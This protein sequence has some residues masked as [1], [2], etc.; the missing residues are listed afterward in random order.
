MKEDNAVDEADEEML[1]EKRQL[2]KSIA[3]DSSVSI[4]AI[5][6]SPRDDP[7]K[8]KNPEGSEILSPLKQ[9]RKLERSEAYKLWKWNEQSEHA[10]KR[11]YPNF[12]L[13]NRLERWISK[14]G[15]RLSYL[16]SFGKNF[17]EEV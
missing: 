4:M 9:K 7:R 14:E 8:K 16:I 1:E 3:N 11:S 5:C 12:C 6:K 10:S 15:G 17:P 13:F 2:L